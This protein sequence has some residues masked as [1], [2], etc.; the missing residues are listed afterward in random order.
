MRTRRSSSASSSRCTQV[1]P[2]RV[3]CLLLSCCLCIQLTLWCSLLAT[4]MAGIF[5]EE[6]EEYAD[7]D[8]SNSTSSTGASESNGSFSQ[9]EPLPAST[10]GYAS[11]G[12]FA[13][14]A[15]WTQQVSREQKSRLQT[16][17]EAAGASRILIF[18]G[19]CSY[20]RDIAVGCASS[21][22]CVDGV[23]IK[24]LTGCYEYA[25]STNK[26]RHELLR[27]L[28]DAAGRIG[29]SVNCQDSNVEGD[30]LEWLL[31]ADAGSSIVLCWNCAW[32]ADLAIVSRGT[33][34]R[35]SPCVCRCCWFA[36]HSPLERVA[37]GAPRAGAS[38]Q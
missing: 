13:A 29:A 23:R 5:G 2:H 27:E 22:I 32:S 26:P 7:G 34:S 4:E 33:R 8:G 18:Q 6:L 35:S 12:D 24:S 19:P 36:L 30:I 25:S 1:L 11:I 3:G 16:R 38:R 28:H 21:L 15:A 10:S 37:A 31:S 14:S 9:N 17:V 20:L